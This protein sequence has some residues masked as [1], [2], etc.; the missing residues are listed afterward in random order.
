MTATAS[1]S[2]QMLHCVSSLRGQVVVEE[3][4]EGGGGGGKKVGGE[5]DK[6]K[7]S[8]GLQ[9]KMK[10]KVDEGKEDMKKA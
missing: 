6:N 3:E 9:K 1:H 2:C 4:G 7:A 10:G 8:Q 5:N